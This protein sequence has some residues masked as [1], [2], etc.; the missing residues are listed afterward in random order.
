M[1]DAAGW[2]VR[3]AYDA[4][5]VFGRGV[6]MIDQVDDA[7]ADLDQVVRR[8]VGRH[9]D[10]D[11]RRAVQQQ[12]RQAR[13][14]DNRFHGLV[15]VVWL[16]IDGIFLDIAQQFI[17]DGSELRLGVAHGSRRVVVLGAKVALAQHQGIAHRP[18]LRHAHER[19]VD[20]YI[21]V[22]VITFEHFADSTG[23]LAELSGGLQAHLIHGVKDAPV[24][25]LEA[26]AHIGQGAAYNDAHGII[27]IGGRH[28]LDDTDSFNISWFHTIT[29]CSNL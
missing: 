27:E 26:V 2:E 11:T 17:S 13:G 8:D 10:G 29:S 5:E 23:A 20:R 7:V 15:I 19:I 4:R 24:N 18:P 28:F 6:G 1:D 12:V 14:H 16:E 21:A 3:P 22:W 9:T 25:R